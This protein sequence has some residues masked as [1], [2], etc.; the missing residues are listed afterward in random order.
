M[1]YKKYGKGWFN[2]SRRHS[3]ARQGIKTGRKTNYA[4]T[5]SDL[6]GIVTTGVGTAGATAVSWI[7]ALMALGVTK[8]VIKDIKKAREKKKKKINY[9]IKLVDVS[10]YK[11]GSVEWQNAMLHNITEKLKHKE[12]L[13]G[14]EKVFLEI[15]KE[16]VK[17]EKNYAKLKVP[18]EFT[19]NEIALRIIEGKRYG[20]DYKAEDLVKEYSI[21]PKDRE[22]VVELAKKR[23]KQT[24]TSYAKEEKDK[25]ILS[26]SQPVRDLTPSG[27][28]YRTP[29]YYV[30]LT[31][32]GD[33]FVV[34]WGDE[35]TGI[36]EEEFDDFSDAEEEFDRKRDE[37]DI[38]SKVEKHS[39]INYQQVTYEPVTT[40][41]EKRRL[42]PGWVGRG[43]KRE[44]EIGKGIVKG[45]GKVG[46]GI[47]GTIITGLRWD[48]ETEKIY[49]SKITWKTK[50]P[51]NKI[52][53]IFKKH[54]GRNPT[55][56]EL[57]FIIGQKYFNIDE[58]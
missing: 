25:L 40:T 12:K 4:Y 39:K 15:Q 27:V 8:K 49:Y 34:E 9:S 28:E 1:A 52:T 43:L 23:V 7:P 38:R 46:K 35:R 5:A 17:K 57:N 37:Y 11:F 24:K 16:H 13:D 56:Q 19:S 54:K 36:G 18:L 33:K 41:T 10:K 44:A 22:K 47:F 32:I 53:K 2:E 51:I 26:V 58:W 31:K 55:D 48:P 3:L 20:K 21:D 6:P 45:V 29:G 14:Y 42:E 30:H 50:M